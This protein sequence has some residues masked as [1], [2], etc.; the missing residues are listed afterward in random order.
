MQA[1]PQPPANA[2]SAT[3]HSYIGPYESVPSTPVS[4][5]QSSWLNKPLYSTDNASQNSVITWMR[6]EFE[7]K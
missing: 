3:A 1:P 7:K 6:K 2:Q 5:I 4:V